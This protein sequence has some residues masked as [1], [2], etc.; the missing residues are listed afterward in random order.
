MRFQLKLIFVLLFIGSKLTAQVFVDDIEKVAIVVIDYCVDENGKTYN[1]SVSNE[2]STYTNEDWRLGCLESFK[3]AG[4]RQPMKM[5]NQCWQYVYTFINSEYKT[6]KLAEEDKIKCEIFRKGIYSYDSKAYN[7]TKIK[8][9]KRKQVEV[10]PI[11]NQRLVYKIDWPEDNVYTLKT[12]KVTLEK[13]KDKVG[14][15][16]HVEIIEVLDDSSYMYRANF[17]GDTKYNYGVIHKIK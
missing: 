5:A 13:D 7:Q 8:R 9:K 15:T 2:K 16:I 1:E 11:K 12:L 14:D 10:S 17:I 6:K 3:K 4:L